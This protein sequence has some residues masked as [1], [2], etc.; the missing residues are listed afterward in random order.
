MNSFSEKYVSACCPHLASSEIAC[1]YEHIHDTFKSLDLVH[2]EDVRTIARQLFPEVQ[3]TP[4]EP[5]STTA[6]FYDLS[7]NSV[8]MLS[9]A[10]LS[11]TRAKNR[12][13]P[14]IFDV[15]EVTIWRWIRKGVFPKPVKIGGKRFWKARDIAKLIQQQASPGKLTDFEPDTAMSSA[16]IDRVNSLRLAEAIA[17]LEAAQDWLGKVRNPSDD[18]A[19]AMR[20]TGM[21]A[22]RLQGVK[23]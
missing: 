11:F 1:V 4:P 22:D 20:D 3:E 15:N 7:L 5:A 16:D 23:Q 9:I 18:V 10:D 12:K 17:S 19:M 8:Q 13:N 2:A 21:I 6:N 14:P